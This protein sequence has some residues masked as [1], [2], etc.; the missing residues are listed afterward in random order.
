MRDGTPVTLLFL[1][2]IIITYVGYYI[3]AIQT[4]RDRMYDVA[5]EQ[6][7]IIKELQISN[8]RL[9]TL[10]QMVLDQ[11]YNNTANPLQLYPKKNKNTDPI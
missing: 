11:Y 4:D 10:S 9:Q 8:I 1:A 6:A 2:F 7:E 5:T 3:H